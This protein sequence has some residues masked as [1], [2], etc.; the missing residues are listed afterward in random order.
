MVEILLQ[1]YN[2][3]AD[4]VVFIS[5]ANLASVRRASELENSLFCACVQNK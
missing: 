3:Y 2:C 4:D 1:I 5:A